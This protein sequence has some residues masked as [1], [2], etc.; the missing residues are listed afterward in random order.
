MTLFEHR[1]FVRFWTA[2]LA[3]TAA[4]QMMMLAIGWQMYQL[5]GSAWDLGLV[6]LAQFV[7]ALGVTLVAGH[8]ADRYDRVRLVLACVAVQGLIA[9][10]LLAST[11]GAWV[12]RGLL[13]AVS[14]LLGALR[15]FQM[16]AQQALLP[17]LVPPDLLARAMAFG[18]AGIQAAVIAGPAIAGLLFA[19]GF[20]WVYGTCA[21]LFAL[22]AVLCLRVRYER[23]PGAR[24]PVTL[25]SLLAGLRFVGAS[26]M[27]LGAVT[28]DLFAVLLGG[29]TALLPIFADGI[30][31][32]GPQGLGLLRSAP[33]VGSLLAAAV[34]ARWPMTRQVGPRLMAAVSVFGLC[35]VVF[36]LATSFWVAMAALAVSGVADMVSVIV[37][38]T[39]MQIATP[40][41]MRGRVAAVNTLFIGASNQLGEFESGATAALLGPVGS[42]VAGGC[43]TLLV[44][45]LWIRL[46]PQ[47]ARRDRFQTD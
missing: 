45:V 10:L 33:A 42:V 8:A 18:S 15:P 37:R 44:A 21:V 43:G 22:G 39:L 35:M 2:R 13:L 11:E 4:A 17:A 28:L 7:P 36:G 23:A 29:A 6:G 24:E 12:S 34:L 14:L 16:S 1:A 38:Q 20:P 25:Q 26:R 47:L 46:F 31:H 5:T 3:G 19:A 41:A 9:L 32:V 30:L 27:L 40:D